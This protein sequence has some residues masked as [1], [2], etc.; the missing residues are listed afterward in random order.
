[1]TTTDRWIIVAL[2]GATLTLSFLLLLPLRWSDVL[3][4]NDEMWHAGLARNIYNGQGFRSDTLYPMQANE[5]DSWPV[6]EP[7]KQSGYALI[8][9]LIWLITG[10]A[11]RVML[12]ISLLSTALIPAAVYLVACQMFTSRGV[13]AGIGLM[14]VASSP[15]LTRYSAVLPESLFSL[16]FLG[17][18]LVALRPTFV[19]AMAAGLI[20]GVLMIIKGYALIYIPVLALYFFLTGGQEKLRRAAVFLAAVFVVLLAGTVL[21]PDGSVQI[22]HAGNSYALAFLYETERYPRIMAPFMEVNPEDPIPYILSHPGD[23]AIKVAKQFR[24]TKLILEGIGGAA[25]GGMLFPAMLLSAFVVCWSA[26]RRRSGVPDET[27]EERSLA[28]ES[29]DVLGPWRHQLLLFLGLIAMTLVFLWS[30]HLRAYYMF[31]LYP[32]M[33]I[34]AFATL[35]LFMPG[36]RGLPGAVRRAIVVLGLAYFIAYPAAKVLWDEYRHPTGTFSRFH[37]IHFLDFSTLR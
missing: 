26:F 14:S 12:L 4:S 6:R 23:Y 31:H 18:I 2:I 17:L 10:P 37:V 36:W 32:L 5:V 34:L 7:L 3:L 19:R 33:L 9:A 21:L 24:R 25:A 35:S 1:M 16:V 11:P 27:A 15:I 8:T 22:F 13:A 30:L 29:N 20:T 28:G